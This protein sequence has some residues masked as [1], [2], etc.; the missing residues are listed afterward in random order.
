[1]DVTLDTYLVCNIG[2]GMNMMKGFGYNDTRFLD[3]VNRDHYLVYDG[4]R[5]RSYHIKFARF[6][7]V[8]K[9]TT[10]DRLGNYIES[11][12]KG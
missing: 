3:D 7:R 5:G 10:F 2:E 4:P 9:V 12:L 8:W 11:S 1:M 6:H